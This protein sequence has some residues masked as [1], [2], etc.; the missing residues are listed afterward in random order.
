MRVA[1]GATA[2]GAGLGIT[3]AATAVAGE[4]LPGS[5]W[6]AGAAGTMMWVDPAARL[7][8]VLMTQYMPSNVYPLWAELRRAVYADLAA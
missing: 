7:S 2:F 6:W 5:Y 4:S 1:D 8:V 3:T